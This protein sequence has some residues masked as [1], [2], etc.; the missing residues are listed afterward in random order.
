MPSPYLPPS[1]DPVASRS[2]VDESS[3]QELEEVKN[4]GERQ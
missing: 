4:G 3:Q 2:L 1:V